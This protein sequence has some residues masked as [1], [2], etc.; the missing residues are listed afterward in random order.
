M[1]FGLSLN[2]LSSKELY[3]QV[4]SD[5]KGLIDYC[6]NKNYEPLY[7]CVGENFI[8][9]LVARNLQK[10]LIT[11][12]L[13]LNKIFNDCKKD[14]YIK[15]ENNDCVV[16][17]SGKLKVFFD[18]DESYIG[19]YFVNTNRMADPEEPCVSS[20]HPIQRVGFLPEEILYGFT[21]MTLHH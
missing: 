1:H 9:V 2:S 10:K 7:I 21:P 19:L 14:L 8:D 20:G 5:L 4:L 12:D 15:F 3:S 6:K 11:R 17:K 18:P 16:R 13:S